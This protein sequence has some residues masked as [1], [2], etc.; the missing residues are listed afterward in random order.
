MNRFKL[1]IPLI[2]F[3]VISIFLWRGL[4]LDPNNV[5]SALIGKPLPKVSLPALKQE[6]VVEREE[7]L[8]QPFLLNVWATWC[9]TCI[10]E[11]PYL[12]KLAERGV[13][14]VGLNYKDETDKALV[15]LERL[16]DPYSVNIVDTEGRMGL[17]LG[18]YGAPETFIVDSKGVIR[19]RHAGDVNDRVWKEKLAP[20]YS[21]L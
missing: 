21:T 5:P 2:V 10:H 12:V 4:S 13:K 9:P 7:L 14:I 15:W 16:G 8:G 19:Y 20:I 11:H 1:F 18:V 17:S 3:V 6:R